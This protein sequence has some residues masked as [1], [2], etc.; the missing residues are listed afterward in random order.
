MTYAL[1]NKLTRGLIH[2]Y[3]ENQG[4]DQHEGDKE[5]SFKLDRYDM[6]FR[7]VTG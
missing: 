1:N 4:E 2:R 7:H 5:F 6:L 3:R